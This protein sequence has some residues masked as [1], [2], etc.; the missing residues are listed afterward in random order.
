MHALERV[1]AV[2]CP[3]P[4]HPT[5]GAAVRVRAAFSDAETTEEAAAAVVSAVADRLEGAR[6]D[7]AVVFATPQHAAELE[8]VA[9]AVRTGLDPQVV[10]GGVAQGVVGPGTEVEEGP[11]LSL[12]CAAFDGVGEALPFRSWA[13]RGAEGMTV[14]GVPDTS[15][16]D[17]VVVLADPFTYPTAEV[18]AR[19]GS[20]RPGHV[21][22]G[23]MLTSGRPGTGALLLDDQVHHEG[24]VGAVLRGVPVEVLVSQGCRPVGEPYVVTSA[25][26]NVILELGGEPAVDRLR[27][28]FAAAA[29]ED[30]GLLQQGLQLGI[31]A[32]EYRDDFTTGDFLIRGVMG[33]DED[34]GSIAVGDVVEVGRVVQFQVRD[35]G[36]ADADLTAHLDRLVRPGAGALLFTCN[37][38]GARFFGEDDHDVR[39]VEQRVTDGVAGAFC[40]GEV[41]PV[42][43]RSFVHGFTASVAVFHDA[44]REG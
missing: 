22:V 31:V 12:W 23:G 34:R 6:C 26:G 29:P 39:S 21:L 3:A 30:R 20:E 33:A 36:S 15:E 17:V 35:A 41:G 25:E 38:R 9:R 19:L 2:G 18:A 42:G 44:P 24:A 5:E 32:D 13:V 40:A 10:I 1:C 28:V 14:A 8:L 7:L 11:G 4:P 43:R 27:E 37:G 16:D